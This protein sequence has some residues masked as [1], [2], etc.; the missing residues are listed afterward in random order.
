VAWFVTDVELTIEKL[1]YGGEGLARL[2][3]DE[4]GRGK[5]VFLPLVLAG[6]RVEAT[7]TEQKPGF[8]RARAERILEPSPE[9]IEPPCRYFGACGGCHYQHTS[10]EQQLEIKAEI[11]RETLRRIA[12]MEP[13]QAEA[14]ASPPWGYR[15]RTRLGVLSQP[16]FA[17]GYR[18][19]GSRE[20]LPVEECPISSPG[21]NRAMAALTE[22]GRGGEVPREIAEVEF[23]ANADDTQLL[24]E[25]T[26]SEGRRP[27]ARL[28]AFAQRVREGMPEAVGV[29]VFS[30]QRDGV[31]V[32]QG[33]RDKLQDAFGADDLTYA[34]AQA[35]YRVS[36][37][38]FFQTNR[39]L[40]DRLVSLVT[41]GATGDFA[42]DLYAGTGLFSL[43]LSQT[44]REVAAVE[45]APVPFHD[46]QR[47]SPSNVTAYRAATDR[48][49]AHLPEGTRFDHVVVDP[50]RAGLGEKVARALGELKAPRLTYVSCDPATLARDLKILLPLGY[51]LEAVHL[52]DLFPQT[53]HIETVV[54]LAR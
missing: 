38:S 20:L 10:Y 43:P 11:L 17:L 1:V 2:P 45:E 40:V 3:G 27:G 31:L 12:K 33:L 4:R 8:A 42:L 36:A 41:E 47:N 51:R 26:Q 48:F 37:G 34:T 22:L 16:E 52:V 6:E 19:L 32:R 23:F 54:Q 50:P 14:H 49:L 46:L 18:R 21:I 35:K 24:L 15:N 7:L 28:A 5:A 44:F 29:A 13:P 9:R 30:R 25:L 39:F 53:F